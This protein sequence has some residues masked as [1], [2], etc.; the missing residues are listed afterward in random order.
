MTESTLQCPQ[1]ISHLPRLS[2]T[3]AGDRPGSRGKWRVIQD[4]QERVGL[5]VSGSFPGVDFVSCSRGFYARVAALNY[6]L[7]HISFP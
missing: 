5:F 4:E 6:F 3:A 2:L 1:R 7:S